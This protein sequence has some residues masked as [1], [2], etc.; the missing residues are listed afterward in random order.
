[1][2]QNHKDGEQPLFE[3][4]DY[5]QPLIE[6]LTNWQGLFEMALDTAAQLLPPEQFPA[7]DLQASLAEM[8]DLLREVLGQCHPQER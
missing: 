4:Q 8:C 7:T 5:F 1:M 6:E 3:Q 2:G